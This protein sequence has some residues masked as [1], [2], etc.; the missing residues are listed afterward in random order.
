MS[1]IGI[2]APTYNVAPYIGEMIK[3]IQNQSFK[4]WKLAIIDDGSNDNSYEAA[5]QAKG[6][7]DRIIIKKRDKHDGRIGYIKNETISLLGDV[8]YLASVDSDDLIT[9]QAL[10][11][12]SNFL[13][14]NENFDAACGNFLC[15]DG[16]GKQWG[17]NHVI[18]SGDFNS[19][20]LLKY[21]C[22]F[23]LRFCRKSI[24]NKVNGYDNIL[25]SSIDYD[26]ALKLDEVCNI[27]R[28][29]EPVSYLYRQHNVQISFRE[30]NEQ[31]LNA[32]KALTAALKRRNMNFKII[33]DKPPF[34]LN[35]L[36][37]EKH[38]IWGKK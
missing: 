28:I 3:S 17:F 20:I 6:N 7:D 34:Q 26:L 35:P 2:Y 25:T 33:N 30:R 29:K 5:L 21:M 27:K 37:E 8:K 10:E 32:K 15:F 23:P 14:N 24:F 13:D 19:Q 12:F 31:N 22:Y 9:N 11:I 4:D 18:N 36:N 38:F 16:T 1:K